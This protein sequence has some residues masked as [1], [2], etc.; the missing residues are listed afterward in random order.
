MKNIYYKI[1]ENGNIVYSTAFDLSHLEDGEH[2]ITYYATDNVKNQESSK[3]FNFYLDKIAP[4]LNYAVSGSQYRNDAGRLYISNRS[5]LTLTGTDKKAGLDKIFYSIDDNKY[6]EYLTPINADQVSGL[7]TLAYYGTD[8]VENTSKKHHIQYTIDAKPPVISYKAIGPQ[9]LRNDTLFART[10]TAF[11]IFPYEA[12]VNQSGLKSV[13]YKIDN[14]SLSDY[15]EKFTIP[16]DGLKELQFEVSDNVNNQSSKKQ[17]LFLDNVPPE[18]N[19]IFSV[20]KIGTKKVRDKSY[21]IYPKETKVYLTATDLHVGTD[22][23]YYSING[24]D[25]I[26]SG[27]PVQYFKQ[28][29]NITIDI[30]AVDLLGNES[31]KSITFSV[32]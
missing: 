4:A 20:D 5:K 32:E 17:I 26:Q 10:L 24:N 8:K 22:K 3:T 7:H 31:K 16:G 21:V 11:I 15:T 14:G 19:P 2:N 9:L 6:D 28:G 1:N 30:R 27:K 25:E 13:K 23:I 12:G 29:A 18:I